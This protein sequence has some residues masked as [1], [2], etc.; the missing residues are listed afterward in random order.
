V[1]GGL[2]QRMWALEPA[3]LAQVFPGAP[4]RDLGLA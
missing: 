1:L 3:R 2:F 4:V